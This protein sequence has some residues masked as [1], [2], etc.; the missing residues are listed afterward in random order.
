MNELQIFAAAELSLAVSEQQHDV[1]RSPKPAA[2]HTIR[3]FEEPDDPDYRRRIDRLSIRFVVEA[4]VA[5][6]NGHAE[7]PAGRTDSFDRLREL[8][9]DG[10]TFRVAE[11]ETISRAQGTRT[12]ACNISGGLGH[13]EHRSAI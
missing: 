13:G 5:A 4:H 11:V 7:R 1:A 12:H 9:H 6:G 2:H 3:V 10:G 8:P